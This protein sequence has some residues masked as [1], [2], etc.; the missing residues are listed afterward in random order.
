MHP[1]GNYAVQVALR[2]CCQSQRDHML[3][4][5]LEQILS[6]A[7]SKHG[8]NV[9]EVLLSLASPMQLELVTQRMFSTPAA[10]DADALQ[11][12]ISHPFGNYV[13]Q[14]LLRRLQESG[15]QA[16][17]QKLL[18]IVCGLAEVDFPKATGEAIFPRAFLLY[19]RCFAT[20]AFARSHCHKFVPC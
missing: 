7:A 6:L 18:P 8:S 11:Q 1:F 9:A 2:S 4:T 20:R 14:A 5:L 17:F 12:L 3:E 16:S 19:I 13:L 15:C 10:N